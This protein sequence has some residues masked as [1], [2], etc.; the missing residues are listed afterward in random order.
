MCCTDNTLHDLNIHEANS[1][2]HYNLPVEERGYFTERFSVLLFKLAGP[3]DYVC[4][5]LI[6]VRFRLLRM[7][8]KINLIIFPIRS[9]HLAKCL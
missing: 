2:I 6:F 9:T 4:E 7:D 1:L 5:I 3:S 8:L